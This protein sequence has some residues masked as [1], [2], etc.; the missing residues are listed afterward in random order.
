MS[1]QQGMAYFVRESHIMH[2]LSIAFGDEDSATLSYENAGDSTVFDLASLTKLFTLIAVM[3]LNEQGKLS[4]DDP[5]IKHA[6]QFKNMGGVSLE[7]LLSYQVNILSDGRI[8][9]APN[10]EEALGRLFASK[11]LPQVGTRFYSDMHA[12]VLKYVVEAASGMD[13]FSYIQKHILIP[14]GMAHTYA[15]IPEEMLPLTQSYAGEHRIEN[16]RYVLRAGPTPGTPHDPKAALLSP[17]GEDLCGHAGLF[18]T[19]TD[20]TS[21]CQGLLNG[22]LLSKESLKAIAINRTGDGMD[23]QY[24][25][26]LCYVKHPNQHFSEVPIY[27]THSAFGL[28]GFTGNHISIDPELK[29][30]NVFLGNRCLNRLTTLTPKND[31]ALFELGLEPCGAGQI[32]WPDG[33]MIYSSVDYVHQKDV[34]LHTPIQKVLFQK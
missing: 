5:L 12:M 7:N 26:Y 31:S 9:D 11:P 28:S 19:L 32:R 20:M 4:L 18:S 16:G 22:A 33:E 2:C 34:R 27:M 10:R 23:K 6:P 30:F 14:C 1:I 3:Q 15:A 24:L 8:D 17:G 29:L 13:F 21:L 25:G